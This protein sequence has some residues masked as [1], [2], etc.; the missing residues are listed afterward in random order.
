M[1]NSL[2]LEYRGQRGVSSCCLDVIVG[3]IQTGRRIDR[4]RLLSAPGGGHGVHA[5]LIDYEGE[6]VAV[7][8][9]LSSGYPGEGPRTLSTALALL[10]R[11]GH[12][13]E[14]IGIDSRVMQRLNDAA[15]TAKDLLKIEASRSSV[16]NRYDYLYDQHLPGRKN[17]SLWS[18]HFPCVLPFAAIEPDVIDLALDFWAEPDARLLTGYRRLEDRVRTLAGL[19]EHGVKLFQKVFLNDPP[20]LKWDVRDKSEQVGRAQ[21]FVGAYMGF[22]NPR[23][24]REP[25]EDWSKGQQSGLLNEFMLL[26]HLFRLAQEAK[27]AAQPASTSIPQTKLH[28]EATPDV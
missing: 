4:V 8:S 21:L 5:F 16:W 28:P 3:L 17:T 18:D 14:E 15:L 24:H 27:P 22:R 9:G 25:G 12:E 11:H 6:R 23:A 26:N 10:D 13:M 19:H 7:R 20:C 1:N 2:T